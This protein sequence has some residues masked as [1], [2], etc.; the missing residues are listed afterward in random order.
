MHKL[1]KF[2]IPTAFI[3]RYLNGNI[4]YTKYVHVDITV[5]TRLW[6]LYFNEI[7]A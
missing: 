7:I 5:L 4:L 2:K 3:I 1:D 6:L